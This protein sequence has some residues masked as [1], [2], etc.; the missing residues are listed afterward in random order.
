METLQE[1]TKTLYM[2]TEKSKAKQNQEKR[3]L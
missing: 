3:H 2:E 1:I